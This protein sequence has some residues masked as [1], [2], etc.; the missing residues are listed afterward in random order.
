MSPLSRTRLHSAGRWAVGIGLV[1]AAWVVAA[2]AP[3]SDF[4]KQEFPVAASVGELAQG[5]NLQLTVLDVAGASELSDAHGWRGD[6]PWLLVTFEAE[7]MFEETGASLARM[8][9]RIPDGEGGDRTYR[10]SERPN[11]AAAPRERLSIGLP[12]TATAAFELPAD[13]LEDSEAN[14]RAVVEF[15]FD[16]VNRQLDSVIRLDVDLTALPFDA[17][18]DI[19]DRAWSR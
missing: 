16:A 14:R 6:G 19:A 5:R 11:L 10:A 8:D 18:A 12:S 15:G 4:A 2:L 1:A 9:L 17:P 7:A 13:A 3:D